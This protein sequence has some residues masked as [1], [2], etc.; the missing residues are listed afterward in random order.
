MAKGKK[1]TKKGAKSKKADAKASNGLTAAVYFEKLENCQSKEDFEALKSLVAS[2]LT[3]HDEKVF[4]IKGEDKMVEYM[5]ENI[6]IIFDRFY[7]DGNIGETEKEKN[8]YRMK[9]ANSLANHLNI[10]G[11]AL[12]SGYHK[13][14]R[15]SWEKKEKFLE[16]RIKEIE[17]IG[18]D[19]FKAMMENITELAW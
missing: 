16:D 17:E 1:S 19:K 3:K 18:D 12:W 13:A 2:E 10:S 8:V 9:V 7:G 15:N 4:N 14:L 11:Q 5:E 6:E